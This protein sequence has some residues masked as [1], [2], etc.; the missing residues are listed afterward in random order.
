MEQTETTQAKTL[1][2]MLI[3]V[4]RFFSIT[5]TNLISPLTFALRVIFT[6]VSGQIVRQELLF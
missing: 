5:H 3:V 4:I 2:I 1:E 6:S